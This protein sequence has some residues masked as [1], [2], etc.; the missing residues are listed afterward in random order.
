MDRFERDNLIKRISKYDNL[1]DN[2]EN[3]IEF[4]NLPERVKDTYDGQEKCSIKLTV[5]F[6]NGSNNKNLII[7]EDNETFQKIMFNLEELKERY[8]KEILEL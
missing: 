8:E 3:I 7:H 5:T 4:I 1:S 2:I 6:G